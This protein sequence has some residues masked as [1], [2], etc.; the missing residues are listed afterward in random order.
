MLVGK[1]IPKLVRKFTERKVSP[2]ILTIMDVE[3]GGRRGRVPLSGKVRRG[4]PIQIRELSGPRLVSFRFLR[5][6]RSLLAVREMDAGTYSNMGERR[7]I[8]PGSQMRHTVF[9]GN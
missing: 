1:E 3:V 6:I 4:R 9:L 5:P 2:F 7:H 8:A